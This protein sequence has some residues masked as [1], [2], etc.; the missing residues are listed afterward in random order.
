MCTYQFTTFAKTSITDSV[1]QLEIL[2]VDYLMSKNLNY[3]MFLKNVEKLKGA[4]IG[5]KNQ[6]VVR[7]RQLYHIIMLLS[8][9]V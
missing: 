5:I 3:F 9:T 2:F 1:F 6:K 4:L 8:A 7:F